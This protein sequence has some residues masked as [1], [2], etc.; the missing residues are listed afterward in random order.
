MFTEYLQH[1]GQ[2]RNTGTEEDEADNIEQMGVLFA[3]V[4]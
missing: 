2:Q 1:V 4:G 3:V